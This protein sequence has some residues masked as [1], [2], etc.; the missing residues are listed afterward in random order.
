M[1]DE[2]VVEAMIRY[3][4]GF[5]SALGT[6]YRLAD[7]DNRTRIKTTWADYWQ[8]YDELARRA[9]QEAGHVAD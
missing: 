5:A 2:D 3:G 6:L 4:G 9:A 8:R 7:R 1:S